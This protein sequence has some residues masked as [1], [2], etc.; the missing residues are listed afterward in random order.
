[1]TDFRRMAEGAHACF[2]MNE[3]EYFDGKPSVDDL[4]ESI[5]SLVEDT[6]IDDGTSYCESGRIRV[7]REVIYDPDEP[8]AEP[9]IEWSYYVRID[10]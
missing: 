8:E 7:E 5:K 10:E 4:E 9:I 2:V 3:W 1:M 6:P